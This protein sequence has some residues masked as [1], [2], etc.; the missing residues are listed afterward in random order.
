V[1]ST[2]L[3]QAIAQDW[4]VNNESQCISF[5]SMQKDLQEDS[6][7]EKYPIPY[8]LY[9]FLTDVENIIWQEA[10]DRLRLQK[11]C[12]LVR[13]LLNESEWILTSFALP[14]RETGWSVQMI[15]DEPD[16]ALTVQTV[17]WSP[18]RVSS[19]HNHATWGIVALIDGEEK[20]TF[21]QRS[22]SAEYPDR[23]T[24]TGEHTLTSGDILC[25]MPE[26]IHQIEAIGDEPTISFNIY[27]ITNYSQRFEFDIE[28]HTAKIF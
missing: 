22:P 8:R 24:K 27:G 3:K 2:E 6:F 13:R 14:D 12:P 28:Q 11:I 25:L 7:T 5:E 17:A 23:L 1:Q 18:Q 4:L 15:Y 26:A 10:D 21:W 16:F 9:R 20:N 19:I